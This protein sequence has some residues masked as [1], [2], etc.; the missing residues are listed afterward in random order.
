MDAPQPF[1]PFNPTKPDPAVS[2][3]PAVSE[4]PTLIT[5][6]MVYQA[7]LDAAMGATPF[8]M[9]VAVTFISLGFALMIAS[10]FIFDDDDG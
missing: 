9:S 5:H 6:D 7:G 10:I 3:V 8:E 4:A 2:E 1:I